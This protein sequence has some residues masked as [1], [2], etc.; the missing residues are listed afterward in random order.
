[1]VDSPETL[2]EKAREEKERKEKEFYR[3]NHEI[4]HNLAIGRRLG[5]H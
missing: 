3:R 1:M 4:A 2:R 5:P